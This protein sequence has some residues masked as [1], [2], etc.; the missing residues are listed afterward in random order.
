VLGDVVIVGGSL[1]GFSAA[2]TLRERGHDGGIAI[3]GEETHQPYERPP[4]SKECLGLDADFH[5]LTLAAPAWYEDMG[6]DLL[7]GEPAYAL[8]AARRR[9]L[10]ASGRELGF[11]AMVIA[12]GVSPR[13]VGRGQGAGAPVV[14]RTIEDCRLLRAWLGDARQVIIVGAGF[15]GLE[16]A[17]TISAA[18][19]EVLVI[20]QALVPLARELGDELGLWFVDLHRRNGV[21]VECGVAVEYVDGTPGDQRARLSDGRTLQAD[22]VIEAVGSRPRTD[23]LVGSGVAVGDGVVC[24]EF[25]R[26]SAEGIVAAGDVA[27]WYNPLFDQQIRVEHWRNALDQGAAAAATLLGELVPYAAVPYFWSDQYQGRVR[28]VGQTFA[29][30]ETTAVRRPNGALIVLYGRE[31]RLTGALCINSAGELAQFRTLI[32]DRADWDAAVDVMGSAR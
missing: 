28:F 26:T 18:G 10:L 29:A 27:R 15:L 13:S 11:D 5:A 25:C 2:R 22:L 8:D 6:V 3:L 23:W 16:V 20:E 9:V 4:L 12:T 1:A 17:A 21:T 32:A 30:T 31:G 7:L 14:L 19:A 24:D